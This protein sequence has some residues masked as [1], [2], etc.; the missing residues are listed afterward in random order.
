MKAGNFF[1]NR[2]LTEEANMKLKF[3]HNR[4]KS[5]SRQAISPGKK[6]K[7]FRTIL[8]AMGLVLTI[9]L[10]MADADNKLVGT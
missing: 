8:V 2:H 9:L 10:I 3:D 1:I 7:T 4:M 6:A 5:R